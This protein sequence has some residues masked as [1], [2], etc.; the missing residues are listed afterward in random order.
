M[1]S[2][3]G[4]EPCAICPVNFYQTTEG[5]ASCLECS[6]SHTTARAGA[7]SQTECIPR[8]KTSLFNAI[9]SVKFEVGYRTLIKKF[10]ITDLMPKN[11]YEFIN[12][13]LGGLETSQGF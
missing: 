2:E 5:Q 8:M 9:M 1:Y 12:T 3:T 10:F 7:T 13:P 4:L 6:S 11:M